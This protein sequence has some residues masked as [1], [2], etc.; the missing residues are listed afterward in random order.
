MNI[1]AEDQLMA[2]VTDDDS[3]S[4]L[5][6]QSQ[7]SHS[8][9]STSNPSTQP[10]GPHSLDSTSNP[11][12]QPQGPH[13][14]TRGYEMCVHTCPERDCISRKTHKILWLKEG[15]AVRKHACSRIKHPRCGD[16]KYADCS[17]W[18]CLN[19]KPSSAGGRDAT[20]EELSLYLGIEIGPHAFKEESMEVEDGVVDRFTIDF[21]PTMAPGPST[22]NPRVEVHRRF[23]IAYIPDAAMRIHSKEK[24]QNDLGFIPAILSESEYEP[25]KNLVGSIHVISKCKA[26][27]SDIVSF[28]VV[29][30]EWVSA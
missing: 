16:G 24:A 18:Q 7:G 8:L 4:D 17:G 12:T 11:S 30:Q 1:D 3:T 9:S 22:S 2:P 25:L 14:P 20:N 21:T 26:R 29:M 23:K 27:H 13:R 5:S 19:N 28:K 15:H 6:T 10:Q